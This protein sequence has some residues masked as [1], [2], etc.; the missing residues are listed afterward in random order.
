MIA[1]NGMAQKLSYAHDFE[2]HI[3]LFQKQSVLFYGR[4]AGQKQTTGWNIR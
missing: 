4:A 3:S 1:R 2:T